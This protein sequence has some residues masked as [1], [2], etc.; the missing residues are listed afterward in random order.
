MA[1]C[2]TFWHEN[3]KLAAHQYHKDGKKDGKW[4]FWD[5]N[6]IDEGE[7]NYNEG[8]KDGRFTTII[9]NNRRKITA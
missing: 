5:E 6:G 1:I 9:K 4:V 3:G 7:G 8:K 2:S